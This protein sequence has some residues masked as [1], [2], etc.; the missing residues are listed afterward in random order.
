MRR[1]KMRKSLIIVLSLFLFFSIVSAEETKYTDHSL[2]RLSYL[3]GNTFIQ[4]A[5]DLAYEEGIVNMPIAEGDRINTT[6]GRAEIYIGKGNYIRLDT[7]TKID[8]TA[9][10]SLENDL[11]QIKLWTG[12]III[13]LESLYE[14]DNIELH[15]PDISI[16]ILDRGLYRANVNDG[17]NTEYFV[18]EGVSEAAGES[19]SIL[20]KDGQKLEATRG[21]YTEYPLELMAASGDSFYEWS[22]ERDSLLRQHFAKRYLSQELDDFEYELNTYGNW[23]YVPPYGYVWVPVGISPHWRPYYNGRWLW[24]PICGWTWLPYEPWGWVTFHYGR[25]HWSIQLGWYWIP[26]SRW[27]PA[28]V[29]WYHWNDYWG[30]APLSYYGYPGVVINNIYY[31][32][33]N[34]DTYPGNSGALTVVHKNK[35]RAQNLSEAALKQVSLKKLEGLMLYRSVP[36]VKDFPKP[37]SIEKLDG[38]NVFLHHSTDKISINGSRTLKS[39]S[40]DKNLRIL[41]D[42]EKTRIVNKTFGYPSSLREITGK[43]TTGSKDS[44]SIVGRAI[45]YFSSGKSQY[46]RSQSNPYKGKTTSKVTSSATKRTTSS[47]SRQKTSSSQSK[48]RSTSTRTVKKKKK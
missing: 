16:Y 27:G 44:K 35:L 30:W 40:E 22:V 29:R 1:K 33:Y 12:N 9:L 42:P 17:R 48:K 41:R 3:T 14:E 28:W 24:Y 25:W 46:M 4:K 2:A 18:Y 47:V 20:L 32:N 45:R 6:E 34:N 23:S 38:R 19:E 11:I 5:G 37:I 7:H 26:H 43:Y 8:F 21:Y 39:P 10:P 13:S 36:A 15:T 31:P